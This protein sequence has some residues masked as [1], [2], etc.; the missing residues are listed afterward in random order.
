VAAA[1]KAIRALAR[2]L[3][4]HPEIR[5]A[6]VNPLC[7]VDDRLVAVDALLSLKEGDDD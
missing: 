1:E 2:L 5:E 6:D 3:E 7:V 4:E